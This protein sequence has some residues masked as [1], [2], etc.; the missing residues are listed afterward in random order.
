MV[1]V[2]STRGW[3]AF[4]LVLVGTAGLLANDLVLQWGRNATLL[5]AGLNAIG[6]V[7]I[8]LDLRDPSKR[9]EN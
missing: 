6:L 5:F 1:R 9:G 7:G 8:G 2:S 4:G 3:W